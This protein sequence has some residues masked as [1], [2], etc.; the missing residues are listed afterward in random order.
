MKILYEE[1]SYVEVVLEVVFRTGDKTPHLIL[2][3]LWGG[4]TLGGA[5]NSRGKRL[6][7]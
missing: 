6:S 4:F 2:K 7:E 5:F 1:H 3:L